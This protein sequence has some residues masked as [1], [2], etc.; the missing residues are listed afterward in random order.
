MIR[1]F[2]FLALMTGAL[3]GCEQPTSR[4]FKIAINPWPGYELLYLAEAKGFFEEA[5]ANIKLVQLDS[6]SDVQ[7]AY[8]NNLVDGMTSTAIEAVQVT[9]LGGK[10]LKVVAI[11]D[12]SN[13][14]DVIVASKTIADIKS[15]A[16][17]RVGA[18]VSSLGIYLLSRALNKYGLNLADIELIN[19][20]QA[21]GQSLLEADQIDAFVTY[22]PF[23]INVLKNEK[24]HTVFTSAE[25]PYEII[26]VVSLSE[27]AL[28][29]DPGLGNKLRKAWQLAMEYMN[30]HRQEAYRL[31]AKRQS[32]S[33]AEFEDALG[34]LILLDRPEQ[35]KLLQN[36][37]KL[38]ELFTDVC[39][40]L[41]FAKAIE[42][43]CSQQ[44]NLA[45]L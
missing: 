33:V 9:H 11:P 24:F 32:I 16:G 12:Y 10:P 25:I 41:V 30:N 6:L 43:D 36:H 14:G 29:K 1:T 45:G 34:G 42:T 20:E 18:E 35:E 8:L 38:H 28:A 2:I 21:D 19:L 7:K 23:S 22:P 27:E 15:L 3:A 31:M 44:P 39:N 26:D 17:K 13:G 4:P 40:T 37:D 5:G